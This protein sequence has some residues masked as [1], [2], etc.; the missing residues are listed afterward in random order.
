[1]NKHSYRKITRLIFSCVML[2]SLLSGYA[3]ADVIYQPDDDFYNSHA[4]DCEYL[5]RDYYANGESGY[6]ELFTEPDGSSLGFAD[7]G[8][9]FHAQ[10]T[11]KSGDAI[12]G[13]VEYSTSGDKIV[14]RNES[15]FYTG[16]IKLSDAVLKY[17]YISFDEDHSAEYT[18]YDGDYSEF[19][20]LQNILLWSF[21]N[22]GTTVG[23]IDKID[24]NFVINS[25]YTDADGI[26]WGFIGYYYASKNTWVCISNP[27]VDDLAAKNVPVPALYSPEPGSEPESSANDMTTVLIFCVAAAVLIAVVLIAVSNKKKAKDAEKQ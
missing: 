18:T 17:D 25:V 27:T 10:F 7:N 20:D 3:L 5:N 6:M 21:P 4:S 19:A 2:V 11:Y 9:I 14:P 1:M 16:W 12:W 23:G 24:E 22:S 26:R 8:G 15:G 13:V